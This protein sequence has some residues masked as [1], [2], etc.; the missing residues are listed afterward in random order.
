MPHPTF[1]YYV[2]Y[3]DF[4][5]LSNFLKNLESCQ[6]MKVNY[7]GSMSSLWKNLYEVGNSWKLVSQAFG[8]FSLY[9][10]VMGE[11][12]VNKKHFFPG[13]LIPVRMGAMTYGL[14]FEK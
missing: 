12:C 13:H 10:T 2:I 3:S 5:M 4:E 14:L 9:G 8:Y 7:L 11:S 1:E 6:K